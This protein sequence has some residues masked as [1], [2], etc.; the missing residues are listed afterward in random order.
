[1]FT[2]TKR[3]RTVFD[4]EKT[5]STAHFTEPVGREDEIDDI[6][7][8]VRP[9][10]QGKE[11]ENLL[12]YGPAGTGKTTCVNHVLDRLGQQTRVRTV[13]INCWKYNTR[14]SFL[15]QLLIELNYPAPRKGK[16]IDALLTVL[17]ERL[18]KGK[19]LAVSLDE[20]DQIAEQDEV[21]YDLYELNAHTESSCGILLT[22]NKSPSEIELD[23]RTRSRLGYRTLEFEAYG[24]D[25][26]K[27]I[28]Q[29]R[30]VKAFRRN[31]VGEGVIERVATAVAD[32]IEIGRGDCRH[33]LEVLHRAGREADKENADKVTVAHVERAMN[34]ARF[35]E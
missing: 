20:F 8:A 27:E 12:I 9:L 2:S 10:S 17:K 24:R 23:R 6:A 22:S 29:N 11:A 7:N 32:E 14:S 1:M 35:R 13:T 4:K 3:R 33:A 18:N 21:L 19:S 28:L 5:L 15:T 16:P 31:T 26:L 30:V 25:D 34:A